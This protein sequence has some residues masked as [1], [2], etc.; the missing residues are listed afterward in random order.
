M[1]ILHITRKYPPSVGGMQ[2]VNFHL[3]QSLK[4]VEQVELVSWGGSQKWLPLALL[5]LFSK[6]LWILLRKD[7]DLIHLGDAFLSPM[8]LFLRCIFNKPV[9]VTVHGKDIVWNFWPYQPLIPRCLKKLQRVIC[10]SKY[11]SEECV[12]RGVNPQ[13][14]TV[15]PNGVDPNEFFVKDKQIVKEQLGARLG[16][17][18]YGRKILLS[19]GR[20]VG[21]KGFHWF[22]LE[23]MPRLTRKREDILYLIA[24]E[25]PLAREIRKAIKKRSLE[26]YVLLVGKVDDETLGWLYNASDVFVMPNI[27]VEGDIEGFGIVVLEAS[28][29]GL[30]VVASRLDGIEDAVEDGKTGVLVE[31]YSADKFVGEIVGIL[32]RSGFNRKR[33]SSFVTEN[34]S[35]KVISTKYLALFED[36]VEEHDT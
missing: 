11:V 13:R 6:S 35:W 21:K 23:V 19:V 2:K 36:C 18:L 28:S 4:E 9:T 27:P 34:F 24:G 16:L 22:V 31:P 15:I 3:F 8:G 10:V 20:L 25:G 5:Y 33:M 26:S 7:I 30:P 32:E 17:D 12:S 14:I 1:R 29:C